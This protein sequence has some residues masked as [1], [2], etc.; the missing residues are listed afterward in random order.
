LTNLKG[1]YQF[2]RLLGQGGMSRVFLAKDTR[3]EKYLAV[4]EVVS[5]SL[6]AKAGLLKSLDNPYLPRIV[7]IFKENEKNYIVMDYIEGLSLSRYVKTYGPFDEE[8]GVCLMMHICLALEYL[9]DRKPPI[10]YRDLKPGN[11]LITPEGN[12]RLIDLGI[13]EE[14]G[15]GAG[16]LP[17]LGTKGYAPPEQYAGF[18]DARSDIYSLGATMIYL[19]TGKSPAESGGKQA[20]GIKSKKLRKIIYTC[21]EEDPNKRYRNVGE[22]IRDLRRLQVHKNFFEKFVN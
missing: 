13:A 6:S 17:A 10:I 9:H 15:E 16:K 21:L 7:D 3:L 12:I 1:R 11:I 22:I 20:T 18:G 19:L 14:A 8:N 4:K 5:E 2:V